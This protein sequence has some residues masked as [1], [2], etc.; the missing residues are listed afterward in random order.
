MRHIPSAIAVVILFAL[1]LPA[2]T[3]EPEAEEEPEA[4]SAKPEG[5]PAAE[6]A[7]PEGKEEKREATEKPVVT[8]HEI[9]VAGKVQKYTATA[10]MLPIRNADGET[11]AHIFFMAYSLETPSGSPPRPLSFCFNGGPGSSSVWLHLGAIGPRRVRLQPDGSMPPPPFALEDNQDTWL[12]QTDLVFIDPVG[13]GYSRP[14]KKELGKKFWGVKGDIESVGEFIRLYLTRYKRWNSPL[15]LAGESYGTTRAAGLSGYLLDQGIALNG[16]VLVSTVLN[17]ETLAF[18]RG[19][20]LPYV[21]YLPS[22]TATAWYHKKLSADLEQ[23]PLGKILPEVERWANQDYAL[24]LA[25]GD[26]LAMAERQALVERLARYTGLS[27]TYIEKA[28]LRVRAEDFRKELLRE[29]NRSA[30]RLDSRFKGID[31]SGISQTPDYDP[32]EAAVRPPFTAAFNNYVRIDLSYESDLPYYILGGLFRTWQWGSAAEGYPDV[33]PD[34]RSAFVRNKF[35]KVLVLEG[36]YDLATPY[37]AVTYTL[38][39]LGLDPSLRPNV[40]V[41]RYESGHMIYID[42]PSLAK[43]KRDV[44]AFISSALH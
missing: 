31:A 20:D 38:E 25:R 18:A 14:M 22:Y 26:Q 6:K 1:A 44:S 40:S 35:M 43:M 29:E 7:K 10:G 27:K 13:T 36:Y 33:S 34:L 5:K 19:N 37:D 12:E 21:L 11:E 41:E 9:R 17:F 30:G 42:G 23:Q 28:N 32:S 16:I 15:F 39:H 24:A 8:H 4:T 2:Q 3:Q